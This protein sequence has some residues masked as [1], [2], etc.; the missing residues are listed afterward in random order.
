MRKALLG[1]GSEPL[2]K[3]G[4]SDEL[5]KNQQNRVK[6]GDELLGKGSKPLGNGG[7]LGKNQ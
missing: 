6:T 1:K 2:G 3:G 7:E 5:G 4:E